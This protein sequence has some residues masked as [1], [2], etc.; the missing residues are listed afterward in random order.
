MTNIYKTELF[1]FLYEEKKIEMIEENNVFQ[2]Y[3]NCTIFDSKVIKYPNNLFLEKITISY[4]ISNKF[5]IEISFETKDGDD[6]FY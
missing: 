3:S 6:I 1:S 5:K 2:I 4:D